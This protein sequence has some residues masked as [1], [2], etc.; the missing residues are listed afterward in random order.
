MQ[1]TLIPKLD[2]LVGLGF[3]KKDAVEMVLRC[4]TLFTFSIENNFRPKFE[5]FEQEMDG[6]LAELR[7]FPQY[8]TFSLEKRIRP[9][10][11]EAL[12]VGVKVPLPV[13]LKS[14]DEEFNDLLMR[15]GR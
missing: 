7:D 4:P 9:R 10:H 13:L 14:T 5:F 11:A 1:N 15:Q 6:K 3:S 12:K 2:Y 8:F